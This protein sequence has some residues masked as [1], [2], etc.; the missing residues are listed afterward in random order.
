MV[1]TWQPPFPNRV[2]S[3]R[4][5]HTAIHSSWM[6]VYF[7]YMA[8]AWIDLKMLDK[9]ELNLAVEISRKSYQLLL[10]L[11]RTA[12]DEFVS[13]TKHN[14]GV[15]VEDA[16]YYWLDEHYDL[17]PDEAKPDRDYLIESACYFATYLRT[18]FRFTSWLG[19]TQPA[20]YKGCWCHFCSCLGAARRYELQTQ[21]LSKDDKAK[22]YE[23]IVERVIQLANEHGLS[24]SEI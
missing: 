8:R 9:K 12:H 4:M 24:L 2:P 10:W 1:R 13:G 11:K 19:K 5:G 14:A 7:C 23:L 17:I 6:A 20:S 18:S 22:A 3:K 21:K 15:S 16:A